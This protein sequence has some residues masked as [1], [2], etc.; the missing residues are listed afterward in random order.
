[1]KASKFILIRINCFLCDLALVYALFYLLLFIRPA[2]F[3]I[4]VYYFCSVILYF[5]LSYGTFRFSLIQKLFG[6]EIKKHRL[7]YFLFKLLWI[8]IVPLVLSVMHYEIFLVLYV[9]IILILSIILVLFT[10]KSL[11]QWC[12]GARVESQKVAGKI[13]FSIIILLTIT[14][15]LLFFPLFNLSPYLKINDNT[16]RNK[17]VFPI[18]IPEKTWYVKNIEQYKQEPFNYIMQLFDKYDIVILCERLH[19]EYTQWEFF[20][21]IILND[22]FATKV[23]N[24]FTEMGEAYNQELLDSY[25]N[26]R[27]ITEEDLQRATAQIVRESGCIWP[28]WDNTNF[29]DYILRLHRYNETKDSLKQ[30]NHYFT[31]IHLNWSTIE[32]QAQRDS[33]IANTNRDSIMAY[34]F[35]DQYEKLTNEK[36]LLITNTRHAWNYGKNEASY[37]FKKYPNKTAVVLINGATQFLYPAMK[38]ALDAAALEIQDSIWAIDFSECPLGNIPFDLIP[39]KRKECTYKDLFVGM[40]YCEHPSNWEKISSYPFIMEDYKDILLK[41]SAF[42]GEKYLK[43]QQKMIATGYYN[44]VHRKQVPFIILC[45]LIF[46][47]IHSI[48]LLFLFLN[49]LLKLFSLLFGKNEADVW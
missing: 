24:V 48:I 21:D 29:Y 30:I 1:M 22:T 39:V 17:F 23:Q 42:I 9:L 49:L 2:G 19:P 12:A 28:V 33:I 36:S 31:D 4:N 18:S 40:I 8:A 3:S 10:K 13:K 37:I 11:W 32:N 15:V 20:S 47:S 45:N 41:R 6:I 38:G 26:A 27:F 46:L 7:N 14:I 43:M 16:I 5:G 34:H 35:I 44:S 25:M